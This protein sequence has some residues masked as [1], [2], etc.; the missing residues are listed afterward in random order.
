MAK[1]FINVVRDKIK[2]TLKEIPIGKEIKFEAC[3]IPGTKQ[4]TVRLTISKQFM[5]TKDRE[6][7]L[8]EEMIETIHTLQ[9]IATAA[10]GQLSLRVHKP[11]GE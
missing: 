7:T 1:R 11:N 4:T 9:T 3:E 5:I 8:V 10:K 6:T 2:A